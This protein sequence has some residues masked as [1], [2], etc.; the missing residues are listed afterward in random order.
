[1]RRI[2]LRLKTIAKLDITCV[3]IAD[4]PLYNRTM[5]QCLVLLATLVLGDLVAIVELVDDLE[6]RK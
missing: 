3:D 2:N 4:V 1:M 5:S 6:T